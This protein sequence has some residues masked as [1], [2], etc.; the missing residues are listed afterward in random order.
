MSMVRSK[1]SSPTRRSRINA[2]TSGQKEIACDLC[3]EK[4][5]RRNYLGYICVQFKNGVFYEEFEKHMRRRERAKN[6]WDVKPVR[7]I[8]NE[9]RLI[10][11]TCL[12]CLERLADVV[13]K[14][15][16]K[17]RKLSQ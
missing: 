12:A 1:G 2:G 13:D 6:V 17:V 14:A 16:E 11:Y 5:N 10:P 3:G 9:M 4:R 7:R 15:I 8:E